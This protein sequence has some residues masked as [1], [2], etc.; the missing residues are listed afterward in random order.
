MGAK[1][2]RPRGSVVAARRPSKIET[3]QS[4]SPWH[5]IEI[6]VDAAADADG[7]GLRGVP[8]GTSMPDASLRLRAAWRLSDHRQPIA[9]RDS[10]PERE[11]GEKL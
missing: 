1:D 3:R 9:V 11:N 2:E 6:F 5:G 8:G 10:M 7:G 4:G